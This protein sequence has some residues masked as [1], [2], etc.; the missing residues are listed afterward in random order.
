[1][2]STSAERRQQPRATVAQWIGVVGPG[3][4]WLAQFEVRYALAANEPGSG[5]HAAMVLIGLAGLILLAG[6]G[7][8]A[9]RQWRFAE[10][11]PLDD[12]SGIGSRTRFMGVLGLAMTAL[13]ALVTV[14]QML[15]ELFIAPGKS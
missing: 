15:A 9:W 11:S 4:V 10:A 14:A 12:F 5:A 6:C 3:L 1:M 13:F 8:L 7:V 2:S